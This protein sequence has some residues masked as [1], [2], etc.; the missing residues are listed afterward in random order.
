MRELTRQRW[1]EVEPLLDVLLDL[2]AEQRGEALQQQCADPE[3]RTLVLELLDA[4]ARDDSD[5]DRLARDLGTRHGIEGSRIGPYRIERALGEGGMGAVFLATRETAEFTQRVALK[6]L[7]VGLYSA[8]QQDLFRREQRIHARLEHPHIARVYDSGITEAGVPYFAMEY[9]DAEA[10]TGYCD[11]LGLDIAARL[12][13]FATI[14]EAVAYAHQNLVV[15]RDLKPS[16][17][18]VCKDGSPKLLDFGIAKLLP[19]TSGGAEPT[20]TGW[21]VFTPGYAAPEQVA[22]GTITTATD[23]YALG[24]MLCE[25]LTGAR[26]NRDAAGALT[27]SITAGLDPVAAA[28]RAGTR[29]ALV[30]RLRGDLDAIVRRALQADPARRYPGAAALRD[31]VLRHLDGRPIRARPDAFVYRSRK[32]VERH[33][34]AVAAAAVIAAVLIGASV[35]SARQATLARNE[36]QRANAEAARANAVKQFLLDLFESSAPGNAE[37]VETADAMLDKGLAEARIGL[38]EQPDVQVDV[39][40]SV[41]DIQRLRGRYDAAR[42]PLEEAASVAQQAFGAGD[43][44]TLDAVVALSRLDEARGDLSAA[45]ARLEPAIA[46]YRAR[47]GADSVPLAHAMQQLGMMLLRQRQVPTAVALESEALAMYRRLLP[48]ASDDINRAS[49]G[50]GEAL[51][52]AGRR[53]EAIVLFREAVDRSRRMYGDTHANV[54]EGLMYLAAPVREAGR[55]GEAE[56]LLREAV[57]INRKVYVKPNLHASDALYELGKTLRAEGKYADSV[58]AFREELAIEQT[59]FPDGHPNIASS[60]KNIALSLAADGRHGEAEPLLREA[61]ALNLKLRG[62]QHPYIAQTRASLARSL[63]AQGKLDEAAALIDQALAAD[64]GRY[65]ESNA[66]LAPDL[67]AAAELALARKDAAAALDAAQRAT[68]M[69]AA[70]PPAH[71]GVLEA[72]LLA[73]DALL[74]LGRNGE[75]AARF[76]SAGANAAAATPPVAATMLRS[77]LGL[78]R[79]QAALGQPALARQSLAAA[80]QQLVRLDGAHDAQREEIARLTA[81]LP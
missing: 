66:A 68:T 55:V 40:R 19:E 81:A 69:L 30:R 25:L 51:S 49:V 74:A 35:F 48:D 59:L 61:L 22:A 71:S 77:L 41:G 1:N 47:S 9:I 75:A 80:Q 38:K 18:L 10:V 73:A 39:L 76:Q 70:L 37:H 34:L 33:L 52:E 42:A 44:R 58:A 4:E 23:V 12:R 5:I 7:R 21:R 64:R 53:D 14:C 8:A 43:P 72:Q 31:D 20:R 45:Q 16:N 32:F 15:H 57:E 26:P 24:V 78:A 28:A 46:A 11:G 79:A 67:V 63:V 36:A 27:G 3:L 17:V 13:L 6:L 60:F 29:K 2:P 56:A 54:A 50:L 62:E 65:G